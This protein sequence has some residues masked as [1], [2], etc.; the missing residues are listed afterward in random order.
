MTER[1]EQTSRDTDGGHT[2]P[3]QRYLDADG[4]GVP[5]EKPESAKTALQA[6]PRPVRLGLYAAYA[7]GGPV[8]I[9]LQ[10]KSLVG[11]EELALWAAVGSVFGV[12]AAGNVSQ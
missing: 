11:P 8:L 4:D 3:P 10:A 5:D 7:L 1:Y 2:A 6:I 12:T 9:Y